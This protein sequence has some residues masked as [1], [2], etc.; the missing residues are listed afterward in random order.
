MDW[1]R[2]L[3]LLFLCRAYASIP[4]RWE[5]ARMIL[6]ANALVVFP[7]SRDPVVEPDIGVSVAQF[8]HLE[9]GRGLL[10]DIQTLAI[11]VGSQEHVI[12]HLCVDGLHEP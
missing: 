10:M 9:V 1:S 5:F 2:K 12:L 7:Q 4:V 11:A 6:K 3:T 8:A